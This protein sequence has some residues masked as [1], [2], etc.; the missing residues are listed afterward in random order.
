MIVAFDLDDTLYR[1]LDY[2][3]SGF[4]AVADHL[5]NSFGV[6]AEESFEV[7]M[8]SLAECGRGR[9]FDAVLRYHRLYSAKRRDR[10]VQA[11]RQHQ[12]EIK[13]PDSSR[14]ALL[15]CR[16]L[17]HR[18]FLVTDG[19]HC[20]QARKIDSLQLWHSFEHC[21]LT[22]RYGRAAAKPS[23]RVF[24]LMLRRTGATPEEL[25]YIADDPAKDFVGIRALGGRTIRVLTGNH[26]AV[27]AQ[28]EFDADLSVEGV[29]L[30]V[31][32]LGDFS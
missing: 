10:L 2:V 7:M 21:Y 13:L 15:R 4:R 23:T 11:Y 1:E 14:R 30:A 16:E 18:M 22:N 26:A 25:V 6:S 3:E 5:H 9:Q 24:E 8:L 19:N 12:P 32:A 31:E 28:P 17:G 29:K 20:V 27:E